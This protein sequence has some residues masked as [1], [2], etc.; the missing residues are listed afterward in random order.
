M[1]S[2]VGMALAWQRPPLRRFQDV[3]ERELVVGGRRSN[4]RKRH[5]PAGA[6]QRRRCQTQNHQRLSPH[7]RDFAR[8]RAWRGKRYEQLS[9]LQ[10]DHHEAALD[11]RQ[12]GLSAGEAFAYQEFAFPAFNIADS[13][14]SIGAVLFIYNNFFKKN[15]VQ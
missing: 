14:I 4:L 10:H 6:Q 5:L 8:H 2:E 13:F 7:W 11:P 12:A 9:L 1:N 3:T 15:L